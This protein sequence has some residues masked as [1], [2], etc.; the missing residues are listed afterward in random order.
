MATRSGRVTKLG[1]SRRALM[2]TFA[3]LGVAAPLW[4]GLLRDA[5]AQTL[6]AH[7]RFVVLYNPHG[8]AA[9]LWRPRAPGGGA[10]ATTGWTVDF[11]PDSSL[12]PLEPHKDSLV[13][14][15]GLDL[16]CNF[17]MNG[18]YLGHNGGCV[19]P[20]TGR[21]ARTP[22]N[23]DSMRT[24]GPS[25]DYFLAKTLQVEP[26]LFSPTG[27]SG[28][29]AAV[30]FDAAGERVA[31]EYELPSSFKKWFGAFMG[32]MATVDPKAA[33]RKKADLAG[34][35]YLNGEAQ[36]LRARLAGPER[37]KLDGQIDG[38]NLIRQKINTGPL[39]P[40]AGCSKP[41]Q[42]PPPDYGP[43]MINTALQFTA[44]LLACN[45]TRVA[46]VGIDPV[47]S[48]KMAW[49]PGKLATMAVHN[50]IAHGYR[51]D[52]PAS[53]RNLSIVH[54]WY[55]TQVAAFIAMLKAIPE[56]NG[57][58]YDNTI[59][60]WTNELGDP[61]RH[62]NNNL[63][64]V[65]AGGG[66]SFKKGRY[67]KF[68]TAPEYKDSPDAHTR[69]LTSLVNQYGANMTVFGDARYPGELPGFLA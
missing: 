41:S 56:G 65:L 60:L 59:I 27:Y 43:T 38:L 10:A 25:I 30:T 22:E 55:A 29:N 26:F 13:V 28:S 51:P 11:D 4:K 33:A 50:D 69:L 18:G 61:A 67:L 64:F 6:P 48:G 23:A 39:A 3:G 31:N 54:R 57:T 66:G 58:V 68:S 9:D 40:T 16:N 53:V 37:I 5:F 62:M 24:T 15:D 17:D 45:L 47:N 36:M 34:L 1:I 14:M 2:K 21:H 52:D 35:D 44:Q 19:A 32:P 63:P 8:C 20:L 49:L 12:G 46:T 42:P 7:P